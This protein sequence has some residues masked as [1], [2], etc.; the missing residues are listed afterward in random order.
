MNRFAARSALQL[1][2][3]ACLALLAIG[4]ARG[5]IYRCVDADGDVSYRDSPCGG[6]ALSS[7]ITESVGACT[8][9]ECEAQLASAR[10]AAE[11]RL[12]AER[13]TLSEMENR[14]LRSEEID[15]QRRLQRQQGRAR[16][17]RLASEQVATGGIWY[18]AYPLY[19][20][21]DYPGYGRHGDPG[22]RLPGRPCVGAVCRPG[23][24]P[25]SDAKARRP[26]Y[27]EAPTSFTLPRP[28]P[29]PR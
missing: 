15:L 8:T 21:A 12:R 1:A 6:A 22:Y 29:P 7:N 20:G 26:P 13:A 9:A 27:R 23:V 14:R 16:E 25:P 11:D 28:A 3:A 5:D 17:A 4:F 2:G 10:A 18:P 24:N 19:P